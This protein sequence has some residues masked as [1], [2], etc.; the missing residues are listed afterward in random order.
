[1]NHHKR[2][3]SLNDLSDIEKGDHNILKHSLLNHI[4]NLREL[5]EYQIHIV[6]TKFTNDEKVELIK[7]Y[8][9]IVKTLVETFEN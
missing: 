9:K 5:N 8:N 4:R 1:M 6:K 3:V 2:S 7:E